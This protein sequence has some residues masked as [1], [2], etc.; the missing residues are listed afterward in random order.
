M[1]AASH[2]IAYCS[3]FLSHMIMEKEKG[4]AILHSFHG[5]IETQRF[6]FPESQ[7]G[8]TEPLGP[9]FT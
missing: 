3:A 4:K 9:E 8:E 6:V 5:K 1:F 2:C 7:G